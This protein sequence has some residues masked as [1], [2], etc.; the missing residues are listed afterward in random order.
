MSQTQ[1][2]KFQ[3]GA[4]GKTYGWKAELAGKRV[5][6]KCGQVMTVPQAIEPPAPAEDPMAGLYDL[7]PDDPP[8]EARPRKAAAAAPAAATG[9]AVGD[10]GV[11]C[12]SCKSAMQP[13]SVL[14]VSCGF[15]LKTGKKLGTAIGGSDAPQTVA[16]P[17]P[18]VLPGGVMVPPRLG[19]KSMQKA[20]HEYDKESQKR[21]IMLGVGAVVL[22][23]LLV[24]GI[25]VMN[26]MN[27]SEQ[28]TPYDKEVQAKLDDMRAIPIDEWMEYPRFGI[29]GGHDKK[30]A[31]AMADEMIEAG[32][33]QVLMPQSPGSMW[34]VAV[35]PKEPEKRAKV[36]DYVN[37]YHTSGD[38][39]ARRLQ[40]EGQKYLQL[41]IH[42]FGS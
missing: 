42:I 16:R 11:R 31:R 4:C 25:M 26:K 15:N 28:L 39:M 6:C 1:Q 35:L 32:A 3:C 14:C 5:K 27:P 9:A 10:V 24:G 30:K 2:A 12:P 18:A 29:A 23:G 34:M 13:G 22:V 19:P 37:K 33:M 21:M 20:N 17:A 38:P 40:D 36:F 41:K 7:V 8:A